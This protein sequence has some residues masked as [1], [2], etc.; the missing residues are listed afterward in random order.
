MSNTNEDSSSQPQF[1]A[2]NAPLWK[3][4][5]KNESSGM[6]GGWNVSFKCNYCKE[7]FDG[8]YYKGKCHLLKIKRGGIRPYNKVTQRNLLERKRVVDEAEMRI[9]KCQKLELLI[10]PVGNVP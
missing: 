9:K 10:C 7:D 4:V 5:T 2:D 3:Y 1:Y 6:K 8:L